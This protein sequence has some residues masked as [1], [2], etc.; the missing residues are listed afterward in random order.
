M[1]VD[2]ESVNE[3]NPSLGQIINPRGAESGL[4][5]QVEGVRQDIDID[6]VLEDESKESLSAH[7]IWDIDD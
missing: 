6:I 2:Q 1:V 5:M 3:D 4:D 7:G